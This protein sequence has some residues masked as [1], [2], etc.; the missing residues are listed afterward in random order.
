MFGVAATQNALDTGKLGLTGTVIRKIANPGGLLTGGIFSVTVPLAMDAPAAVP[1]SPFH[2][3][4][5]SRNSKF[6]RL[7]LQKTGRR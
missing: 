4:I 1:N 5:S 6:H 2:G 3:W 7:G